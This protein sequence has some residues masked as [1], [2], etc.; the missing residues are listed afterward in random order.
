MMSQKF[1]LSAVTTHWS[2]SAG[3]GVDTPRELTTEEL[4]DVLPQV[5]A[6]FASLPKK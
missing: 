2:W 1:N 5:L 3:G 6:S 4:L